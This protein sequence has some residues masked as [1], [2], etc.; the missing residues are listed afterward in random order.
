MSF[1][2]LLDRHVA[3]AQRVV[4]GTDARGNDVISNGT[5]T[6]GIPAGRDLLDATE[7]VKVRDQQVRRFVYFLPRGTVI[8]GYDRI[9]DDGDVFEVEGD[10]KRIVRRRGGREHHVE[11]NVYEIVS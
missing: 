3:V 7:D 8:S 4:T 11:A 1:R 10:P 6:T 5:V 2:S 9:V